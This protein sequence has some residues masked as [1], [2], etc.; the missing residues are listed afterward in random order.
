[1]RGLTTREKA[2]LGACLLVI[3]LVANAIL[4]RSVSKVLRGSEGRIT[5][6]ENTL[7]DYEM[8]LEEAEE[9][10]AKEK[11]LRIHMPPLEGTLGRAQGDLLQAMQDDLFERKIEIEQQSLQDIVEAE[12]Y[13]EVAVRLRLRGNESDVVEWLTTLQSPEQFQVIKSMQLRLDPRADEEEPQA[14]CE[15]TLARWFLPAGAEGPLP[16]P[17]TETPPEPAGDGDAGETGEAVEAEA[18]AP[19]E[20]GEPESD[21]PKPEEPGGDDLTGPAPPEAGSSG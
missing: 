10:A 4:F 11:W 14:V 1:M 12:Y 2:L 9:A 18:E 6:L 17:V 3:F 15:I 7:A 21:A 20:K 8:W 19:D 16:E 5:E 13:T